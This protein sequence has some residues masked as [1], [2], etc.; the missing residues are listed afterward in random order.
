M[1]CDPYL[2]LLDEVCGGFAGASVPGNFCLSGD[3]SFSS[4]SITVLF[5]EF[6]E[7]SLS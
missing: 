1:T 3:F 7:L 6:S 5:E 2:Y 4:A